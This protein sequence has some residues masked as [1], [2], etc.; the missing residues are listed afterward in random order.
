MILP[1][2]E[3]STEATAYLT[4]RIIDNHVYMAEW[5]TLSSS[6]S[7]AGSTQNPM[8]LNGFNELTQDE[9]SAV[10][11]YADFL[12]KQMKDQLQQYIDFLKEKHGA[13]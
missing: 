1:G 10:S 4:L 11:S 3:Q 6:G 5:P 7:S 13:N 8:N 9:Q 2:T 12:E